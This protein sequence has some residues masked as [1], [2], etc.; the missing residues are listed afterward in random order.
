MS[1]GKG[2]KGQTMISKTQLINTMNTQFDYLHI[3]HFRF[4]FSLFVFVSAA[5][6]CFRIWTGSI[7]T[8]QVLAL[9]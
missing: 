5:G 8:D 9:F 4:L 3:L 6:H 1:K 7:W 2:T